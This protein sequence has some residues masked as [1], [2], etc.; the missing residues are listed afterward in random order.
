VSQST[1]LSFLDGVRGF[2]ATYVVLHH[3]ILALATPQPDDPV[4]HVLRELFRFG[5][6]A[7]DVFIVLS[8]YSLMLPVLKSRTPF[9]MRVFLLRRTLRII[10]TY[11][12]AM[13]FSLALIATLI[14]DK[15]GTNWDASLPVTG[16]DIASHVLL[17]H[18]WFLGTFA[19]INYVFWSIG[20]EWKIYFLF[21]ALL[22]LRARW[23]S[24]SMAWLATVL[25]YALWLVS[26]GTGLGNPSPWGSSPYYVG[27]FAMGMCAA[28]LGERAPGD[29]SE[30]PRRRALLWL[31]G[32]AVLIASWFVRGSQDDRIPI[33]LTSGLVGA[34]SAA[35]LL[36]LRTEQ[37]PGRFAALL[38]KPWAVWAG[39]RGYSMYLLHA[40]IVQLL[41]IYVIRPAPW[42]GVLHAPCMLIL[43]LLATMACAQLFH[44]FA[45]R[46]FHELSRKAGVA[47][48][49]A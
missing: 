1:R 10:P 49:Q 16:W 46:P 22:W 27:L 39:Q 45:E 35:W 15:T 25:G 33:V 2:A 4:Q 38:S 14:G 36:A 31:S 30:R 40:P 34:W 19:K 23:G 20:V 48:Q 6:Y 37:A 12:V 11:Y 18:D 7:V 47:R 41:C 21:P 3:A 44:R 26:L 17:I 13:L 42:L 8:G 29:G 32:L 43:S 9:S 28:D 24:L 5:H